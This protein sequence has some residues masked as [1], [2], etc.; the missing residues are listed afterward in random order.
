MLSDI[1]RVIT[2]KLSWNMITDLE[3]ALQ[4]A[5]VTAD[6]QHKRANEAV[7]LYN[8]SEIGRKQSSDALGQRVI[9]DM[10]QNPKKY[11]P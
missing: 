10:K 6:Y 3:R 8:E 9:D 11:L 4:L 5:N 1:W 7:R 2:G